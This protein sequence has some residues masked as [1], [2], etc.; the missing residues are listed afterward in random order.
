M[1]ICLRAKTLAMT[2]LVLG[3]CAQM[4]AL[5]KDQPRGS[6]CVWSCALSAVPVSS[7]EPIEGFV[8]LLF[9]TPRR[10][11]AKSLQILCVFLCVRTA[12]KVRKI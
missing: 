8:A 9:Q 12:W 11:P 2:Q 4:W 10:R 6:C 3:C 5:L 1:E 7:H